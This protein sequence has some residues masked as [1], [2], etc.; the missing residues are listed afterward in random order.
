[1]TQP[2]DKS[3]DGGP[4]HARGRHGDSSAELVGARGRDARSVFSPNELVAGRFK[5][6]RFI[7]QGGMGDVYEAEDLELR[8][9]VALKTVRP[10]IA[11][12]E[13]AIARFKREIQLARRVT[14]PNVCRIFD[15]EYHRTTAPEGA[16]AFL[17]ME[18]LPGETLAERLRRVGR[19][20]MAEAL[21]LVS[22]MAAALAAAHKVGIVHR[23]FKSANVILVPSKEE[24]THA[25][26]TDFGLAR[27]SVS[28]DSLTASI[29]GTG[30]FVGTPAYMAPEQ[31]EGGQISAAADIYALGVVMYEMVTGRQPFV[32]DTPLS[33]AVKRLKEAPASP[34]T[35]VPDLDPKWE[36][37][38]LRCLER[39][40]ADRFVSAMDVVKV[41][42]GEE[43]APG[44]QALE[45]QKRKAYE[46]RR[47]QRRWLALVGLT[48][49]VVLA[50]AVAHHLHLI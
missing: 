27:G 6:V 24:G 17:T 4:Q 34:R 35:H 49:V 18:L 2:E 38:I 19:L 37:A 45:E 5:I 43:V 33:T 9:R 42:G 8:E 30:G 48:M 20:S 23:D 15:V 44:K 12:D 47:K 28:G 13:P 50:S 22:Q 25:V 41:L 1:M 7:G 16:I 26:V 11:A 40:P 29:S 39:D 46:V 10:E 3:R 32:G 14:H 31:V 36:S 21:P